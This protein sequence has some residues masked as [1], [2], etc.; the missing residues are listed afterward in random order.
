MDEVKLL[1]ESFN[2]LNIR[3]VSVE[4]SMGG[5]DNRVNTHLELIIYCYF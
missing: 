1:A 3:T 2:G 5:G 4:G